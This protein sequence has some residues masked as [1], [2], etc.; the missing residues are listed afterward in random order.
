M[1]ILTAK[2]SSITPKQ[3]DELKNKVC[4]QIFF[5]LLLVDPKTKDKY[6][7]VD[8]EEAIE[9]LLYELNGMNE[10]LQHPL[11]II[12]AMSYLESALSEYRKNEQ[13]NFARY[14]KLVL[15]AGA[16]IKEVELDA[17]S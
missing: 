7:H 14:R 4:R 13:L 5:L 16:R 8:V 3:V 6:T 1:N 17:N 10:I 12:V 2:Y 15:D 11:N 9:N